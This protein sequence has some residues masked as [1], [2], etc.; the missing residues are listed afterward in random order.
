MDILSHARDHFTAILDSEM[1]CIEV[2]EWG[3]EEGKPLMIYYK[4]MTLEQQDTIFK[5][6]NAGSLKSLAQVLITRARHEDGRK[7]FKQAHMFVL[8]KQVDPR[9][10]ER[11]TTEMAGEELT[12][13]DAVKN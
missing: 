9:V 13:E 8:M 7:M 5:H 11:I 12:D 3:E 2:P 6:V 1:L 10:V 4:P